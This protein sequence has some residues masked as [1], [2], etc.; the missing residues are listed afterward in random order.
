MSIHSCHLLSLPVFP[1]WNMDTV[2]GGGIAILDCNVRTKAI[3]RDDLAERLEDPCSLMLYQCR[4]THFQVS[5][6]V[7]ILDNY[8]L[9]V[10][11]TG[12]FLVE[13]E[14]LLF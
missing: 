14:G 7:N 8:Y 4:A 10:K 1:A 13:V 2:P 3:Y 12:F 5:T 9:L 6:Y 11:I